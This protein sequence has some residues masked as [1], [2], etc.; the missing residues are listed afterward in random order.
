[1]R[2]PTTR[3][4]PEPALPQT[5]PHGRLARAKAACGDLSRTEELPAI[6]LV[7]LGVG[8][9]L[10]RVTLHIRSHI[11]VALQHCEQ[12]EDKGLVYVM[13]FEGLEL[14]APHEAIGSLFL[15]LAPQ[16]IAA[17]GDGLSVEVRKSIHRGSPIVAWRSKACWCVT[18]V[19]EFTTGGR[20]APAF[21]SGCGMKA[22]PG[23][24]VLPENLVYEGRYEA[25]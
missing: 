18:Y 3:D 16:S 21:C 10:R 11:S 1:M 19:E 8:P 15:R 13:A 5:G 7:Q 4:V 23:G 24:P 17:Y 25:A 2:E 22:T 9:K 12:T 14:P 20:S 6:I